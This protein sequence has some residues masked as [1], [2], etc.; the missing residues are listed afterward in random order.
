[1]NSLMTKRI[2]SDKDDINVKVEDFILARRHVQ[3]QSMMNS[4]EKKLLQ[5]RRN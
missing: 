1:M 4:R 3:K 2:N 5:N